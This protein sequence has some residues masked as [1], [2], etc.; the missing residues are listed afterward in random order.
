MPS[1]HLL[2]RKE[3]IIPEKTYG[4]TVVVIDTLL[5]TSTI[6]MLL[7]KGAK[8]VIPAKSKK[9][10]IQEAE[11]RRNN[12]FI[13][14]GEHLGFEIEGFEKP[15]PLHLVQKDITDKDIILLTTNGTVALN[16]SSNGKNVYA[17]S[18]FTAAAAAAAINDYHRDDSLLIV[19]SGNH[20]RFSIEDF[21]TA[22]HLLTCL[23]SKDWDLSDG[24]KAALTLY[25]N[26]SPSLRH[27]I[28]NESETALFLNKINFYPIWKNFNESY[29][30]VPALHNHCLIRK[31][32]EQKIKE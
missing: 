30:F 27:T 20:G 9:E 23:T 31:S 22:D 15:D 11:S 12:S 2:T 25:E 5:A 6:A 19:C 14:A 18:P 29:S 4:L 8:S 28:Y 7:N 10:A 16:E 13:L 17:V 21:L 3:E 32:V 24:S 1:V 26:A